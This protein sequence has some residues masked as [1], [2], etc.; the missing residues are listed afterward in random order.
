[1]WSRLHVRWGNQPHI[2][3]PTWGSPPSCKQALNWW[4]IFVYWME[5]TLKW[6]YKGINVCLIHTKAV[7]LQTVWKN[8]KEWCMLFVVTS[9][10]YCLYR[11]LVWCFKMTCILAQMKVDFSLWYAEW[12]IGMPK[13]IIE[14]R[15][16]GRKIKT[17]YWKSHL[18]A[19]V[20]FLR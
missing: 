3:S 12:R 14:C 1:M 16:K 9:V 5:R 19:N 15:W 6:L 20:R 10:V 4:S 7:Q 2:I 18:C 8:V 17:R 11:L 13:N